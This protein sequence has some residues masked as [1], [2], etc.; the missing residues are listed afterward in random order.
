MHPVIGP[1]LKKETIE[2]TLVVGLS[3]VLL[4][5]LRARFGGAKA[6][7]DNPPVQSRPAAVGTVSPVAAMPRPG[8]VEARPESARRPRALPHDLDETPPAIGRDLFAP[9]NPL[10]DPWRTAP[11]GGRE[12][13]RREPELQAIFLGG[14]SPLAI[15]NDEV[16]AAGGTVQ[17]SQVKAIG[18]NEVVLSRD[19]KQRTLYL[20]PEE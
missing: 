13:S 3:L 19:G 10:A 8:A 9:R 16:V 4:F 17:G 15:I 2:K 11:A 20:Y 1:L 6:T 18:K 14:E 5:V 7:V 12:A